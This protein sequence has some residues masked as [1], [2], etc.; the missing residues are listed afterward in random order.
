MIEKDFPLLAS[1]L[2]MCLLARCTYINIVYAYA[3]HTHTRRRGGRQRD[4][5]RSMIRKW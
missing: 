4:R 1:E 5:E 3:R 2:D